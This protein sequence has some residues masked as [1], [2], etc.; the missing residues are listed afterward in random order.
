MHLNF[1]HVKFSLYLCIGFGGTDD[2]P[3]HG[4]KQIRQRWG[5]TEE[6][7]HREKHI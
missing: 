3:F 4:G 7:Y 1:A 2:L 5:A 6:E